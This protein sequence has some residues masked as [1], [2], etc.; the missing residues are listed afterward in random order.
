MSS[1]LSAFLDAEDPLIA[2]V[3]EALRRRRSYRVEDL[4]D[5]LDVSPKRIREA[6]DRLREAGFRIPPERDGEVQLVKVAPSKAASAHKSLLDGDE[7]T[8]AFVSDTHLSSRECALEHLHLAY[9]EFVERGITEVYHAGDLVAGLGIYPTQAQDVLEHTFEAQVQ[10]AVAKYPERPGVRTIL[11]SG[12]HDIEGTFGRTGADPVQAVANQR[13]DF[14]YLGPYAADVEL[15]NGA[16]FKMVHGRGGGSYAVS[17]KPQRYVEG[18]APGRKPALIMFGHWHVSGLF[19][20]RNVH[21]M[22]AGCFEWQTSLL[23]RVGLQPVVG[24]WIVTL[25][26]GDDGTVV[27]VAPEF[28]QFQEG[29][30]A[31]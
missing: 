27:K 4:A 10:N 5:R 22:L 13:E 18:L 24:Y 11:I 16:F 1:D 25:R 15:A 26:L 17:Y 28:T 31:A 8:L 30:V 2:N 12:N 29:R 7:I 3:R 20:H 6:V 14:T 19:T 23:V 21:C 9:D